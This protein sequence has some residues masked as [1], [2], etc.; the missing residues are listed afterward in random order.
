M[1]VVARRGQYAF[2]L[3]IEDGRGA[4]LDLTHEPTLFPPVSIDAALARGYW[5]EPEGDLS[6]IVELAERVLADGEEI[7]G[8]GWGAEP[9]RELKGVHVDAHEL[10]TGPAAAG[11]R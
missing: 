10:V 8:P 1:N 4:I 7:I 5:V 9:R 6:A 3:E 2:L 11:A